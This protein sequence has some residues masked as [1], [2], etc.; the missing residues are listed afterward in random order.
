MTDPESA[1]LM[2]LHVLAPVTLHSPDKQRKAFFFVLFT[3][4]YDSNRKVI[5]QVSLTLACFASWT[6]LLS[7]NVHG[8]E[9][10]GLHSLKKKET[11]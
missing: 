5:C 11:K 7:S 6:R 2:N 10:K 4:S 8:S 1:K 9:N 3:D